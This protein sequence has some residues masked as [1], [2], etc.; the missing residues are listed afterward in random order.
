M[1]R[2]VW[3]CCICAFGVLAI[4]LGSVMALGSG[5]VWAEPNELIVTTIANKERVRMRMLASPLRERTESLAER[6]V[7]CLFLSKCLHVV[8]GGTIAS[9]ELHPRRT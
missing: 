3:F 1:E 8:F 5:K 7:S 6:N 9:E 4:C 2:L